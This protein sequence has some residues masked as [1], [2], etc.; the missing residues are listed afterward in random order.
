M[1]TRTIL[2]ACVLVLI[3]ACNKPDVADGTPRCVTQ[4]IR[5]FRSEVCE[6][7]GNVKAY[8]FQ[9]NTVY[10]YDRGTCGADQTA[11]VTDADCN[12]LG[13]LGG[14]TGNTIINGADFSTAVFQQTVWTD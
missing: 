11:E 12:T 10:V 13:F 9:N 5:S 1:K 7:G 4:K 8:T 3:T 14:L 6:T 2:A